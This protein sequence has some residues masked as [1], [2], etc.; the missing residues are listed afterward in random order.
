MYTSAN[1]EKSHS[2]SRCEKDTEHILHSCAE[3]S[4]S[5]WRRDV[6]TCAMIRACSL[7]LHPAH[8]VIGQNLIVG[9][10]SLDTG[11]QKRGRTQITCIH[12]NIEHIQKL[13]MVL[14]STM[15]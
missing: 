10:H 15:S 1:E 6:G 13:Q 2:C 9:V 5:E 7:G 3:R 11:D 12:Y 14:F 4:D 8:A